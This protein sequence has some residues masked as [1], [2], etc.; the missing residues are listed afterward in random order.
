MER[1]ES[2]P[3]WAQR[4]IETLR[5]ENSRLSEIVGGNTQSNT[6]CGIS[7]MGTKTDLPNEARVQFH[8]GRGAGLDHWYI[9]AQM[10]KD[11]SHLYLVGSGGLVIVPCSANAFSVK[12]RGRQRGGK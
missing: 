12:F 9:E 2:L 8:V 1:I 7:E 4:E 11:D 6:T 10:R 5:A 3:V